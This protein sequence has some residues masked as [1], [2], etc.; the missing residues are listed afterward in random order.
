ME[1]NGPYI[2]VSLMYRGTS[3]R[4]VESLVWLI[5]LLYFLIACFGFRSTS[6][7]MLAVLLPFL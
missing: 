1:S 6:A 3:P 2:G 4:D 5:V 7:S